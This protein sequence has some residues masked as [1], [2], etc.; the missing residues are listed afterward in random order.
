MNY[1]LYRAREQDPPPHRKW[2]ETKQQ[3]S[4]ETSGHQIS[5]CFLSLQILWGIL[6]T[7]PLDLY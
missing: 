4:R 5:C 3:P 7:R 1:I 2:K 6:R